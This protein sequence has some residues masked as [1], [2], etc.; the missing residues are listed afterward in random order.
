MIDLVGVG[1][2]FGEGPRRVKALEGV[3]LHVGAGEF[4]VVLGPSGS[5]KTTLLNL[6]GALDTATEG[7]IRVGGVDITGAG[8]RELSEFRRRTVSFVFQSFNIFPGLTAAEN[9]Q[10][11]ID[12]AGRAG[13]GAEDLLASVGLAG[14]GDSFP[15]QLS[16]G[17][18]QRVAIARALATGN[19]VLLA[20]E[21]TGELDFHTGVQILGLLEGRA[22]EGRA[23]LV[24]THNREISRAADRVVELSSGRIVADGPPPGGR[25]RTAD[26]HW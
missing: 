6:I 10:F 2:S 9:V 4:V 14:R 16:G 11:G 18:Q 3:N 12:V 13:A 23:V 17:E 7:S 20:D 21:P 25:A 19:P 5:G 26:L 24:V 1:K 15:H 22:A 8:R